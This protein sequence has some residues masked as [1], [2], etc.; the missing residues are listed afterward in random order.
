M[1]SVRATAEAGN[2]LLPLPEQRWSLVTGLAPDNKQ[3]FQTRGSRSCVTIIAGAPDGRGEDQKT[4]RSCT[5]EL[6]KGF[7]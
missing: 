2:G 6:G 7:Q 1:A 4:I 5:W 3:V